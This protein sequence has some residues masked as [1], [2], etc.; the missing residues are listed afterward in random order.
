MKLTFL[1]V[2]IDICQGTHFSNLIYTNNHTLRLNYEFN[3]IVL[4]LQSRKLSLTNINLPKV[5]WLLSDRTW[6]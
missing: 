5:I 6:L 4:I 2:I 1:D 3:V